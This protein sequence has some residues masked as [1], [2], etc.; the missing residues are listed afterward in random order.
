MHCDLTS[1]LLQL[2]YAVLTGVE[3]LKFR[4]SDNFLLHS[5]T[6]QIGRDEKN[7][8]LE[9]FCHVYYTESQDSHYSQQPVSPCV[10]R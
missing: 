1:F 2:I 5:L 6:S 7:C 4:A 8:V 10:L 3:Y 9:N